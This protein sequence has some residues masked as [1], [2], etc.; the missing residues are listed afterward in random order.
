MRI[1]RGVS[2]RGLI[3]AVSTAL[4]L[5]M[6]AVQVAFAADGLGKPESSEPRA[7]AVREVTDLGAD[8]A[9]ERRA[10]ERRHN[11][12]QAERAERE[13]A[14]DPEPVEKR[15]PRSSSIAELSVS[16]PEANGG[17]D[18]SATPLS[19]SASWTAGGNAG[20]FT[21]GYDVTVPQ[22]PAGP[23]PNLSLNYD[24]GS[25]DGRTS[26][27]NNQGSALG[28]G[29][30]ITESYIER[31]Y[32]PCDEDGHADDQKDLCWKYDN[33]RLVLN[34]KASRLVKDGGT[35]RLSN[36]DAAQ[37][38]RHTGASNGDD[39]GEYWTVTTGD[40]TVYTFGKDNVG[41]SETDSVWTVPVYGD[42]S[43]EPGYSEGTSFSGRSLRQAWRWNLDVV[44]DTH[45]NAA[46]YWYAKEINHYRKNGAATA[47]TAYT[48]GGYL[49]EIRYGQRASNLDTYFYRIQLAH[50]E[51]CT[52]TDCT[53]L[54]EDTKDN[55]PDVPFEALCT[56]GESETDCTAL[57]P[58]YFSR[59]RLTG[60]TTQVKDGTTFTDVDSWTFTQDYLDPG[61][62]G[63]VDDQ[64]LVLKKIQRTGK[65]GAKTDISLDPVTFTYRML[66]NRVDATDDILPITRPRLSTITTETG[67]LITVT[68]SSP[69]CV[70]SEVIGAP[71]D[72]NTRSCYPQYWHI[73]GASEASVD[74]FHKYRVLAVV[75]TDPTG[76]GETMETSYTYQDAAWHYSDDPFTPKDERTWS[77]WRGYRKVTTYTGAVGTTRS[78]SVSIYLQGMDGDKTETGT[79]DVTLAG[80][81]VAGLD[82]PDIADSDQYSGRLRQQITYNGDTPVTVKVTTPWSKETA[83]QDVPDAGDHIARYVR[84]AKTTTHTYLTADHTWRSRAVT[85]TY[86]DY[87]MPVTAGDS[88]Q[89]GK[90][91]DETCTRTWYARN[92]SAGL[93]SLVSRELTVARGCG[94]ALADV[95]MP[96]DSSRRGEVLSDTATVYDNPDATTW[97]PDQT[98]TVGE[99]TWTGRA[100]GYTTIGTPSGWQTVT[101]TDYDALGRVTSAT[102][103]KGNTFTT[104]YTPTGAGPLER[105][106]VTNALGHVTAAFYEP[107]RGHALRSYDVNRKKT[108]K[109]FDALGR[110]T[111]VWLPN[112]T[113]GGGDSPSYKFGY[114][115]H[116]DKPSFVSSGRITADGTTY[117]TTYTIYDSLLRKLQTQA[118]SPHGGRILTD[119]RYNSR[120]L[121]YETYADIF[122]P[123]TDPNGLYTR[124]LHGEAPK[125]TVTTYDGA[126]RATSSTLLVFGT[127]KWSTTTTYTGDSTATTARTGGE[128]TRSIT[129]IRGNIIESRTYAGEQPTDPEY[130]GTAPGMPYNTTGFTFTL[131][132]KD[133]TVTGPDGAQWTYTYDLFG[134][135]VKNTDPD[136]GTSTAVHNA[137]DQVVKATD[138]RGESV[139]T[140][141][142]ALGRVTGTW[143]NEKT[144]A[145][146]L[147]GFTYDTVLKGKPATST[148]YQDGAAYT[149]EVLAYDT[150]GHRQEWEL[151]LP[152]TDPLV[153]AGAPSTYFF[154]AHYT[155]D[156]LLR[157]KLLPAMGGL[158]Q[159][160]VSYDYTLQGI[161]KEIGGS[162]GYLLDAQYTPT[163]L[164]D[165]LTLGT[166]GTGNNAS[167][168]DYTYEQGTDRLLSSE[169]TTDTHGWMLQATNYTYDPAGNV[170]SIT[171]PTTLD[172]QQA[173]DTQ[174][175]D[176]DGH[177]RLTNAWTPASGNCTEARNADALGGRAPYWTS[178]TYNDA[179]QRTSETD[180]TTAD[181]DTYCYTGDQPHTLTGIS[182]T[183]DCTNPGRDYAYDPAGNTTQRPGQTL[184]WNTEGKLAKVTE[185]IV[186]TNYLY[187]A[188]GNLLVR[189]T[190]GGERV[191]YAGD[192]E[193][194]LRADGTMWA[195]RYYGTSDMTIAVR[196]NRDTSSG[197][198]L[199]Y[200]ASDKHHTSTLAIDA[201]DEQTFVK[202]A[203]APFGQK[204]TEARIGDWV[205]DKAFIGKTHDEAT[206][207]THIGAR[208]YDPATGMFLSLDPLLEVDRPQTLNGYSYAGQNPYTYTDPTGMGVAECHQG[209]TS[210]NGPTPTPPMPGSDNCYTGNHSASCIGTQPPNGS[211]GGGA[212]W[213]PPSHNCSGCNGG[214]GNQNPW[215][216]GSSGP[217]PDP[218]F[219]G[220]TLQEYLNQLAAARDQKREA[221]SESLSEMLWDFS[222]FGSETN[223]F[224]YCESAS[225]GV[226]AMGSVGGCVLFTQGP[227]GSW[228]VGVSMSGGLSGVGA[229]FSRSRGLI[230]S[231]ADSMDQLSGWG[232]TKEVSAHYLLGASIQHENA[233][234]VDGSFVRN[235]EGEPV[236]AVTQSGGL[237]VEGGAELGVAHTWTCSLN[238]GCNPW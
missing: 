100:T 91:G 122:D 141:Y 106:L 14:A 25:I 216:K 152:A 40:G 144:T 127:E 18:Y 121:A 193:L 54:T 62:I 217:D 12:A 88:G 46:T 192:T 96:A 164:T 93:T 101:T 157:S 10:K 123:T 238:T 128:A 33:A 167:Y 232:V 202:R 48:R 95:D 42:D 8:K 229:G 142:D 218:W 136:N 98:P 181:T 161:L 189:Q 234:N 146:R 118:P 80:V 13:Q 111:G 148:R 212:P 139:L 55:W 105:T 166:G 65:A 72:T 76:H 219:E 31:T 156:G 47:N 28:E 109:A 1:G 154:D 17:G 158:Q 222:G 143:A 60:I 2:A 83:R 205:D 26:T 230:T 147:T 211:A 87:G 173:A 92:T 187:D 195:Q 182:T 5:E 94:A 21:W 71:E 67:G 113:P 135:Q 224:G 74:W 89:I 104:A 81:D 160:A 199:S 186:D 115:L 107:L 190:E 63:G 120:G 82:V 78:K 56:D 131:D 125:Q 112:R 203:L 180:H 129:D 45:G 119:T 169:V 11:A 117:T 206:G 32:G 20:S 66:E 163:G 126:G 27:T 37:V 130:G 137:L 110:L 108:E 194:H 235:T 34:G 150:L 227:D 188:S 73:N 178:Y 200:L 179:G 221:K 39:N 84:D 43:G 204:R 132:G 153:E 16:S 38:Q 68:Y 171:D 159:E 77:D 226:A 214:G 145:H 90:G 151:Q 79:R 30:S 185:G 168:I 97:T 69:E 41:G 191:L 75:T 52:A 176:Y 138:S 201:G 102:D 155:I 134:R 213:T 140:E 170:T 51:R 172:G 61:D 223:T 207:L 4:L 220:L 209:T 184:T 231:N 177:R 124:A 114:H 196:S 44:E 174:C 3:A 197:T 58:S 228:D 24:S 236:T 165:Y 57:G 6:G 103:A 175:F 49:K 208:E 85:T 53:E 183:G 64:V 29:F 9:R 86:D 19:A 36:D 116:N 50:K 133:K 59:K 22:P 99:A 225:G 23:T 198:K 237:G 149:T 162:T 210:C 233:V 70:R 7:S 215:L 15:R 35:W